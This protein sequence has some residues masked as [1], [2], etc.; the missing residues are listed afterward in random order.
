M[1]TQ[2]V[3]LQYINNNNQWLTSENNYSVDIFNIYRVPYLKFISDT[4]FYF[5]KKKKTRIPVSMKLDL[6]DYIVVILVNAFT[7]EEDI[8]YS[9][10]RSEK[11]HAQ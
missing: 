5:S 4:G 9:G 6:R 8:K 11:S 2:L 7:S 3:L 10:N 1:S